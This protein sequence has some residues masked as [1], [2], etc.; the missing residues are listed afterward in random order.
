ME[1]SAAAADPAPR[2][3]YLGCSQPATHGIERAYM[4]T[5]LYCREHMEEI[6]LRKS[7]ARTLRRVFTLAEPPTSRLPGPRRDHYR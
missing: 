4:S 5:M 6:A 3:T 7:S 1:D 2:C